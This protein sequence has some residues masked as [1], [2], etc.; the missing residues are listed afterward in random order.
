MLK[1]LVN[2]KSRRGGR[3]H[4]KSHH[5]RPRRG[6]KTLN[7]K[8]KPKKVT[9]PTT[10]NTSPSSSSNTRKKTQ[11]KGT[12]AAAKISNQPPIKVSQLRNALKQSSHLIRQSKCT[13]PGSPEVDTQ[14]Q[15]RSEIKSY[16]ITAKQKLKDNPVV[17]FT[18]SGHPAGLIHRYLNASVVV[19]FQGVTF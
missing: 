17:V 9:L 6:S 8:I 11:K 19:C 2:D 16:A 18:A 1:Q 3:S 7:S 10:T 4:K 15:Q 14:K 5:G 13:R 12:G